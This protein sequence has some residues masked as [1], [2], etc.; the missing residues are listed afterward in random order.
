[1]LS[2]SRTRLFLGLALSAAVLYPAG[3]SLGQGGAKKPANTKNVS[4][5]TFDGVELSGVFYPESGKRKDAVVI[6]L[7]DFDLKKGGDSQKDNWADLAADLQRNGYAVLS[8]DFRGFGES[9][10]VNKDTFWKASINGLQNIRR[11]A[12][13]SEEISHKQFTPSYIPY[14]V[15]DIAAAKAYLDRQSDQKQCN[16]SSVI[17]IGAGEGATLGAMWMANECRRRKDKNPPGTALVPTLGEPESNDLAAGVWL[18]IS[19]T[20]GSPNRSVRGQL[21]NWI[22]ETGRDHKIPMAFLHGANDSKGSVLATSLAK[23][24]KPNPKGKELPF[25]LSYSIP[26]TD[27]TGQLLLGPT[28]DTRSWIVEK[29][30]AQVMEA[31]GSKEW[32]ERKVEPSAYWYTQ[33]KSQRPLRINKKPGDPVPSVDVSMLMGR[34]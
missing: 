29:Y 16:T 2:L 10:R 6:L 3:P 12:K 25:T 32:V 21:G 31:R 5:K 33:P 9:T 1:M 13:A 14:L 20:L 24:I 15:N 26:K 28:L 8:F 22:A 17:L 23:V 19:P 18:S 27:L 7:H 30:L 34:L 4:F 11:T